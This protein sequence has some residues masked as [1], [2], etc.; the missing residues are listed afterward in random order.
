MKRILVSLAVLV[1]V[2]C[3]AAAGIMKGN[4][5]DIVQGVAESSQNVDDPHPGP[6]RS[7]TAWGRPTSPSTRS[8]PSAARW[9]STGYSRAAA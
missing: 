8:G 1:I 6:R 5:T 9:P 2:G 4:T 3:S 7:A